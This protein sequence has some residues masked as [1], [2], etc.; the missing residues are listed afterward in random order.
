MRKL[1][2]AAEG[3]PSQEQ[4]WQLQTLGFQIAMYGITPYMA[5]EILENRLDEV[6][7]IF[8]ED[9]RLA[10]YAAKL[11]KTVLVTVY[12]QKPDGQKLFETFQV[13]EPF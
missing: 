3:R 13:I 8:S 5:P 6:Q 9:P 10:V 1:C 2:W 12:G 4:H 11:G 7:A